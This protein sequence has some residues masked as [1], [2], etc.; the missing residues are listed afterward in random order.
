MDKEVFLDLLRAEITQFNQVVATDDGTW[1][2]KGFVDVYGN[3]YSV[4]TDTK[5]VSKVMEMLLLPILLSFAARNGL[6]IE[7]AL[8]QNFY[9]D[10]TFVTP[11]GDMFAVDLKTTYRVTPT[12][13]NGMTLGAFTGYFRN[14]T[15]RKNCVHPYGNYAAHIVLGVI[16]SQRLI[17]ET[18]VF[19]IERLTDIGSPIGD[20]QFFVQEKYRLATDRPG[21]GNTKNIGSVVEIERLVNGNGPFAEL[22]EPLFDDYWMNY[23]TVDMARA[24][25][26][27]QRAYTNLASYKVYRGLL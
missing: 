26:L 16:Y 8:Q 12:R 7:T 1:V 17:E 10:T 24:A 19:P 15:S 2:V 27:E 22:G 6:S 20:F 23:N 18:R 5:V 4:S 21:S 9:P 13:V 14:R 11:T 3:V 25:H